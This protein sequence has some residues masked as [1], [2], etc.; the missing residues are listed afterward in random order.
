MKVRIEDIIHAIATSAK[1]KEYYYD[2]QT[3]DLEMLIDGELLGSRDIDITDEDRYIK[4]PD[5]YE[6]DEEKMVTEFASHANDPVMRARLLQ[7]IAED[8]SLDRFRETVQDLGVSAQWERYRDEIFRQIAADWCDY[9]D[10]EYTQGDEDNVVTGAVYEHFKGTR[11]RVIGVARHSETLE[12]L[13]VYQ[14]LSGDKGLWARPKKM[15]CSKVT[16]NG[17]EVDRFRLIK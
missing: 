16:V 11:Y 2:M 12:E 13:V 5:R 1:D 4:L 3:G 17:E 8:D 7:A 15:F 6:I 9:N 10:I 14:A